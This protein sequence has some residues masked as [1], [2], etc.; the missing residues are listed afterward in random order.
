LSTLAALAGCAGAA[1]PPR[2]PSAGAELQ[3]LDEARALGLIDELLVEAEQ[4]PTSQDW[5]VELPARGDL[6]VDVRLGQSEVGI[7]WVSDSDRHA[8]GDRLPHADPEGQLRVLRA[9]DGRGQPALI[10]VLD[11]EAYRFVRDPRSGGQLADEHDVEQRLRH[12]LLD[13][14]EYAKSQYPL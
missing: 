9:D 4:H 5:Q 10:L 14:I 13:F 11:H 3:S 7:E 8:Y 12:D 2:T 6:D 1:R